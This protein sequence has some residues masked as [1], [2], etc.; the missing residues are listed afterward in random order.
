MSIEETVVA[1]LNE[2]LAEPVST[3]VPPGPPASYVVLEKTGSSEDHSLL[4]AMIAVQSIAPNM[5]AAIALNDRVKS[6]MR[7]LPTLTN[8][9]RCHCE[10]DHNFSDPRTKSRRYQAIFEIVYKE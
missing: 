7:Q 10:T 1:F 8:V 2:R 5:P 9:F 3:E 4:T 6:A